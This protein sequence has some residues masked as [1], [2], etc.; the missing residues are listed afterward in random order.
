[1]M[2]MKEAYVGG[3]LYFAIFFEMVVWCVVFMD[4]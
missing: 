4:E 2:I 3:Y 1:M